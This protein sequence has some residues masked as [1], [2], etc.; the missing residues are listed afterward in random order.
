MRDIKFDPDKGVI[1]NGEQI[2]LRGVNNHHDLGAL[3]AAFNARAVERQLEIL[4]DMGTNAV[5]MSHNPP[6]PELL[7]LTDRMGFLVMDE[8]FDSW[9]KKKTPH[10][11]H[12]IFPDWH[13]ADARA[14]LRRD[15]NH[16]SIIIWSIGNEVGEQYDGEAGAKIGANW[17]PSRIRKTRPVPPP[18]R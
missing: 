13:E 16:P 8:V 7:E 10:D 18:A 6:A 15:R 4:R 1:V 3:G 12:L 17:S 2:P 5:R 14:M 9:E 11:F